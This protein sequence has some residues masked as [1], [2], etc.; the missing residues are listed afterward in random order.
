MKLN[1][2]TKIIFSVIACEMIG[3]AG[4]VF[5]V[6]SIPTWYK[7]LNKPFFSPP[8]W[9]F[10]PVWTMLYLMMGISAGLIWLKGLKSR[11][12]QKALFYFCLQLF[13]NFTW[14]IVF[15]GLHQPLLAFINIIFLLSSILLTIVKFEKISKK[16][17]YLLI[18]Y[19][20]WVTFA[21]L[22]NFSIV[23]LNR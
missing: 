21:S 23:V 20:L 18:P 13:L 2:L 10:G 19:I 6:G 9:I 22:L 8:N 5:T 16:A 3:I 14:S 7:T 1:N 11:K 4:S 12:V 15:F 17:A